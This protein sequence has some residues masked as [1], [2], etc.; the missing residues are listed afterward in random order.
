MKKYILLFLLFLTTIVNAQITEPLSSDR[1]GQ[2]LST[3]VVGKNV[4]QIQPGVDFFSSSAFFVPNSYF[5]YGV[6]DKLELNFNFAYNTGGGFS[7]ISGFNL[8]T[9]ISLSGNESSF[10]S[11]IQ[12][13]AILPVDKLNFGSQV[14]YT[15]ASS[16]SKNLGWTVNLGANFD[17]NFNATGLYVFNL[18]YS[19]SNKT[20]VFIEPFGTFSNGTNLAF[21]TGFYYLINNNF[22]LDILF[23]DNQGFFFGAGATVRFLPKNN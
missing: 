19:L 14:V 3:N 8:G 10:S 16:L 6:S 5:R 20:G 21:D 15:I 1:P 13:S 12:V 7:E 9:R 2:A 22:Q 23:G 4:F 11:A 17:E 18:S